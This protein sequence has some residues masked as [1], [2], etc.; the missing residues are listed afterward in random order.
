MVMPATK[1]GAQTA[2]HG[3]VAH[4]A[5]GGVCIP[6]AQGARCIAQGAMCP[7]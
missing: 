3:Q 5:S 6:G 1:H 2:H 7:C 4:G